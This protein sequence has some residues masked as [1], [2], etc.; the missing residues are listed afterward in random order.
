MFLFVWPAHWMQNYC[1][2][3]VINYFI[4][5]VKDYS[6]PVFQSKSDKN[7]DSDKSE[8]QKKDKKI[9]NE[10]DEK[11]VSIIGLVSFIKS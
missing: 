7:I 9:K 8:K 5:D 2:N 11:D 10:S 3:R 1:Y 6:K 4:S